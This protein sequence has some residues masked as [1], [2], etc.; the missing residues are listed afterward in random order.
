VVDTHCW[1]QD[2]YVNWDP[3]DKTVLANEQV[4]KQGRSWRSGIVFL[5]AVAVV[6]VAAAAA[7]LVVVVLMVVVCF[8]CVRVR[9]LSLCQGLW[10]RRRN[11][12]NGL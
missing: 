7:T 1:L 4:D 5:V 11:S 6:V 2:E 12:S 10:W 9:V 8:V 3:V